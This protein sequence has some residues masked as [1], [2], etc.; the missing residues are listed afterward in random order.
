MSGSEICKILGKYLLYFSGVLLLPLGGSVLY[1]FFIEEPYFQTPATFAFL[2]TIVVCLLLAAAASYCG[3]KAKSSHLHRKEGILF[4][5]LI[6]ILTAGVSVF[7]FQL[8][9]TI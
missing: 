3:R 2:E 5:I 7:P 4:V 9:K 8:Q 1:D 6:W